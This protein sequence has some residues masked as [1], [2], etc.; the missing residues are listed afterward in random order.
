MYFKTSY[1]S[2][3]DDLWMHLK[4]KYPKSMFD[5]DGVGKQLDMSAFSKNFF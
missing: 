5:V 1:D 4:S 3:F 2:D